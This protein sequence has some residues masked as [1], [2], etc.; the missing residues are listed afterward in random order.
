MA[1]IST[2]GD[3]VIEL[4]IDRVNV[5]MTAEQQT[6]LRGGGGGI[7]K[8]KRNGQALPIDTT[9]DSVNVEVSEKTSELQNDSDFVSSTYVDNAIASAIT[10]T[11]NAAV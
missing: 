10:T 2:V 8:V 6:I 11:L 4:E 9:D 3:I 5:E 1:D 7:A